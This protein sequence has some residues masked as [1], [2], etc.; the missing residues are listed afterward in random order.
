MRY[1]V[2][3]PNGDYTFGQGAS[4]FLVN[5]PECVAQ[6]VKTRLALFSG[7]WF[8]DTTIG[9]PYLTEVLGMGTVGTYDLTIQAAILQTQGV[10]SIDEYSSSLNTTTRVLTITC[11]LN[12][13]YGSTTLSQVI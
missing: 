2:L 10:Q 11:N 3:D 5:S 7:E 6:A 4:E 12:T 13:I 8:L 9:V 1:R